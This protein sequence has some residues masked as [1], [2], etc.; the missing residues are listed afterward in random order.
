MGI[1]VSEIATLTGFNA[2]SYDAIAVPNNWPRKP[3]K[4]AENIEMAYGSAPILPWSPAWIPLSECVR[5]DHHGP[6]HIEVPSRLKRSR[7][8]CGDQER[9]S[10][11]YLL[12]GEDDGH[13][14][15]RNLFTSYLAYQGGG[16]RCAVA[17]ST[18][19]AHS[20]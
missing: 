14:D 9:L 17:P 20:L 13:D 1:N 15:T 8:P 5:L 19:K 2:L 4:L 6:S 7:F 16:F 3:P 11:W 18:P 12:Y 10:V